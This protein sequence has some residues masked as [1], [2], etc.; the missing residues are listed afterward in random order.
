MRYSLRGVVFV[1]LLLSIPGPANCKGTGPLDS[2]RTLLTDAAPDTFT[3]TRVTMK[4]V[5]VRT[6]E[7]CLIYEF[8][9][10]IFMKATT[11]NSMGI[12]LGISPDRLHV[13]GR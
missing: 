2:L 7:F 9:G 11:L 10:G 8:F 13:E 4:G 3:T 5:Y 6:I 1:V 12:I